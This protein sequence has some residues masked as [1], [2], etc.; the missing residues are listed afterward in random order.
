MVVVCVDLG[1]AEEVWGRGG[2]GGGVDSGGGGAS[3]QLW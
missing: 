1:L 3:W 2:G